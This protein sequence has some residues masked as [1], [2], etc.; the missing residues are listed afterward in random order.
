MVSSFKKES[1]P[2]TKGGFNIQPADIDAPQEVALV[3][4]KVAMKKSDPN[5]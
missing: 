1:E 2:K 3:K 5:E 4:E